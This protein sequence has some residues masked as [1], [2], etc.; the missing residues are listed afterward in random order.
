MSASV[1]RGDAR[2][3]MNVDLERLQQW[4]GKTES[5]AD[6]ITP[7][8][9]AALSAVLDRDDPPPKAGDLLPPL[10][11]WL[12]FLPIARQ[13][14]IGEDGHPRRGGFLPPVPLKQRMWAGSR[15]EFLRPLRIGSAVTR[16]SRI[17][18]VSREEGKTGPLVFVLVRHEVGDADGLALTDEHNIVYRD[19]PRADE[20][21]P[22]PQP[23]PSDHAWT[24]EIR[25]DPVL[26]FRYSALTFNGHRIH[27]DRPYAVDVE[28]HGG[29]VVHG[30]LIATLLLDLLRRHE[31]D[32]PVARFSFRALRPLYDTAPFHVCGARASGGNSVKLWAKDADGWLAMDAS[33][34]LS[35]IF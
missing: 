13:S 27:Y 4:I 34:E 20:P 24:R 3:P 32:A 29:L 16:T 9:V 1:K 22:P 2:P 15:V 31:P 18:D 5:R 19:L 6:E 26:L 30:P 10:W 12:Y 8:P 35:K 23:A 17:A 28:H 21:A 25:P 33:A 11:H 7:A 14:E